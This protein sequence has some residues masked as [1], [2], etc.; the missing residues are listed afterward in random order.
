M[1]TVDSS[2]DEPIMMLDRH[3]GYDEDDGYGIDG[4]AFAREMMAL[5]TMGKKRIQI[6]INSPGGKVVD[7]FDIYN[8]MLRTKTPVDTYCMGIAAS[9]AGI[10]F[11]GGRNRIMCDYG[12]LMYHNPFGDAAGEAI[13][14]MKTA[15]CKMVATRSSMTDEQVSAMMTRTTYLTAEEAKKYGLCD[16]IQGSSDFNKK[17]VNAA[18]ISNTDPTLGLKGYWKQANSIINNIFKTEPNMADVSLSRICNRLKLVPQ[19]NEDAVLEAITAIENKMRETENALTAA[20]ARATA[21]EVEKT[22]L[23]ATV[24]TLKTEKETA[25]KAAKKVE[26]AALIGASV[27]LGIIKNEAEVIAKWTDRAVAD[28]DLTKELLESI[29]VNKVSNKITLDAGTGTGGGSILENSVAAEMGA[30]RN[31]LEK[32]NAA[33]N[34][35]HGEP[36]K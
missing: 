18:E 17:R 33:Y 7:G 15:L 4:P 19:A 9:I 20:N 2:V 3:I 11:Q 14:A 10:L 24:N 8:A 32:K 35:V 13:D 23:T 25:E 12:V 22:T 1:Y 28:Y 16:T 27:K 29:T 31:R 30:I 26:A 6:W 36:G 34:A 21:L 5:D